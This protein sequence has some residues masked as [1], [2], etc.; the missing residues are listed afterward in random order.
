M[1]TEITIDTSKLTRDV[2]DVEIYAVYSRY[3]ETYTY[4]FFTDYPE[5]WQ[6]A[7]LIMESA[8][9]DN[10]TID[11]TIGTIEIP[12]WVDMNKISEFLSWQRNVSW[13]LDTLTFITVRY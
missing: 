1:T 2:H 4:H 6:R 12:T 10:Q 5:A 9:L 7:A 8:A 13:C 3:E 11:I